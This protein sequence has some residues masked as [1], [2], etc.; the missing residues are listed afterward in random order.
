MRTEGQTD[1]TKLTVAFRNFTNAPKTLPFIQ[2]AFIKGR[3]VDNI[4]RMEK[5]VDKHLRARRGGLQWCFVD[6]ERAFYSI[7]T[8]DLWFK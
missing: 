2:T 3:T 4:D 6:F 7:N 1:M 8:E 5:C